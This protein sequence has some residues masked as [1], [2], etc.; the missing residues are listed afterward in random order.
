MDGGGEMKSA[1]HSSIGETCIVCETNKQLGIHLYT[2]FICT[3]CEKDMINTNTD[4]PKYQYYLKQLK[5]ITIPRI[6]S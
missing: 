5:K 1:V 4:D 3:D 2:E 6:Y